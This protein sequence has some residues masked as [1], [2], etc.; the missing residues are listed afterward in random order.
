[1]STPFIPFALPEIGDEEIN[2]VVSCLKSGW[3]TTGPY[4]KEFEDDF[5]NYIDP[6][7][8]AIALNSATM[9]LLLALE[10]FGIK[11]GDEVIVPTYTFSA[12]AMMP[13]HLG[14]RP[15]LVDIEEDSLNIDPCQIEAAITP[16]TKAIIPVHFAGL[17]CEM[18]AINK[19]AKKYNLIVIEDAA[20]ALPTTYKGKIIGAETSDAT[21]YSFYATKTITSGEGGM[22][23]SRNPEL[24]KRVRTMR[25]HGISRDV[26]D[27]YTAPGSKWYYEIVAPG[28]KCNLTDLAAAIGIEQL[29][30]CNRF[31]ARRT[32]IA[33]TYL[34]A[35]K[36]LP[37][38][39]PKSAAN[40][41]IHSWHLFVVRLVDSKISRNKFIEKMAEAGI[42][43]SV[44]FIPL[45]LQPYYQ[46]QFG[47]KKGD[48]PVAENAF[49]HAISLP[50][51]TKLSDD[52]VGRIVKAVRSIF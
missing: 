43:C 37:L 6:G 2:S 33:K 50:I 19:I 38:K 8:N 46:K 3:I 21:V 10:Y 7:T 11:N 15:V 34:E 49:E 31:H 41:D 26:F 52:E 18:D 40:G 22:I 25:L 36:N 35:F 9:G 44:H 32:Q 1:M 45:H 12:S 17:A 47:Y 14:A 27:R 28:S 29:K 13:I 4:A 23:V 39:L 24:A 30:K 5:A 48:F 20:H 42:G 16:K 51:Y